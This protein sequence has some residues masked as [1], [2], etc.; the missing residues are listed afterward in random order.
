MLPRHLKRRIAT[1]KHL[2][3][4]NQGY[5]WIPR[6]IGS[7]MKRFGV[8]PIVVNPSRDSERRF[9]GELLSSRLSSVDIIC[10][11]NM[12]NIQKVLR[13]F[14]SREMAVSIFT[15]Q[16]RPFCRLPDPCLPYWTPAC[17]R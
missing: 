2:R 17:P 16:V 9:Q 14:F 6:P 5:P 15:Y 8:W 11:L 10:A 3:K 4:E 12:I 7:K 1:C 13:R